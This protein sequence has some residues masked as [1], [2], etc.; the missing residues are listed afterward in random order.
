[1]YYCHNT[2][3]PF[4]QAHLHCFVPNSS[5]HQTA[6]GVR[7]WIYSQ[8]C[9]SFLLMLLLKLPVAVQALGRLQ[10]LLDLLLLEGYTLCAQLRG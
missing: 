5:P 3:L 7:V 4:S 1:M 10:F 2:S 9:N 6:Q 8:F